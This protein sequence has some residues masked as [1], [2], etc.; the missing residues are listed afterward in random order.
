MSFPIVQAQI[1]NKGVPKI[2]NFTYEEY[3]ASAQNWSVL[4]NSDGNMLFA[5]NYGLLEY[6]GKSW[7]LLI[8]PINKTIIRSLL[9]GKD[10]VIY[11]GAQN[12]IGYMQTNDANQKRFISLLPKVPKEHRQMGDVWTILETSKG[13]YFHTSDAIYRFHQDT[14][15]VLKTPLINGYSKVGDSILVQDMQHNLLVVKDDGLKKVFDGKQIKHLLLKICEDKEG[16]LQFISANNGI[17]TY[18]NGSFQQLDHSIADFLFKNKAHSVC[19]LRNGYLA[20]GTIGAGLL[21]VDRNNQ[22]IQWLNHKNGLQSN[23]I[24]SM[25]TD[26]TGNLWV[27]TEAGIDYV[28]ISNSLYKIANNYNLEGA[29]STSLV[30]DDQLYVGTNSGLFISK[31]NQEENPLKPSL[32]FNAV[33]GISGQIWNLYYL[34]GSLYACAHDGLFRIENGVAHQLFR[35]RGAWNLMPIPNSSYVLQGAY[36]GIH[37]YQIKDGLLEFQWKIS[38]FEETSRVIE[39][40]KKNNIWMA[41]GYKGIYKLTL[42]PDMKSFKRTKLYVQKDGFP[43]RLFINLFKIKGEIIF[44]TEWGTYQYDSKSDRMIEHPLYMDILGKNDHIRV[45]KQDHGHVW[46]IKGFDMTDDMG[47][48]EFYDN[49]KHELS[50]APLQQLRGK[51]NPGFEHINI[52]DENTVLFGTKNGLHLLDRTNRNYNKS[53]PVN[54]IEV[55]SIGND[56]LLFG[57]L[58]IDDQS[59][60]DSI[61]G[62]IKLPYGNNTLRF[63]Y[64]SNFYESPEQTKYSYYLEGFDDNWYPWEEEQLKTYTNLSPGRYTFRFKAQN[65][66]GQE[67]EKGEYS[68]IIQPPWFLHI[69]AKISYLIL[70]LLLVAFLVYFFKKR[71]SNV[72]LKAQ[73]EQKKALSKNKEKYLREKLITDQELTHLRNQKLEAEIEITRSKM[74]VLNTEMA[75]SVMMITQKNS[76][77][78]NIEDDLNQLLKKAKK[79]NHAH[80]QKLIKHINKDIN[81]DQDWQQFKIHFDKVHENFLDRL[82]TAFP[83][84]TPKDLQLA[85]YLRLNLSSKEIS[86]LMNITLRSVEGCRYRLRKH[87]NLEGSDNLSEFMLKF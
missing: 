42:S 25:G 31:W 27:A 53:F 47:V 16:G 28:E 48:I 68:F 46:Y 87:I 49:E 70:F 3:Q 83:K 19:K 8:Q 61:I 74:A 44:G 78:V 58:N 60:I 43:S 13:I 69:Y 80:I 63:R 18:R 56:S 76:L 57:Q 23:T 85:A 66:Y 67:S 37:L 38:G 34:A 55:K 33:K 21:I 75:A 7:Q 54:L 84:I 30:A 86:T 9:K 50:N 79:S 41:H 36:D 15:S 59:R 82:K 20:I 77:L 14:M 11:I 1:G 73:L 17:Q 4:Q 51:F 45:L 81:T 65:V 2:Q 32:Q 40:D 10:G 35:G 12:E 72:Q 29:V 24:L 64:S 52:L 62:T 22:P 6:N 5:N 39:I 71:I 26:Q